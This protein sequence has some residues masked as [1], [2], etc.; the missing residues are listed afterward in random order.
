MLCGKGKL[1][2]HRCAAH[3]INLVCKA[4]F[5]I[6]NS[7]VH[8][9][10]EGVKYIEGS[11]SRKQKFEEIIQQLGI[12]YKK[13]PKIDISTRWNSTYLM[14]ED[15]LELKR[16][17]ESLARQEPEYTYAPSLEEGEKAK[18]VCRFLKTFYDATKV[19][20]GSLYPTANLYFMRFGRLR[21]L[22]RMEFLRLTSSRLSSI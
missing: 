10:R 19:M 8:K 13:R 1:L 20:S 18:M 2:H 17:F 4:G 6:I 15:C 16:A 21:L 12:R 14:L 22:W 3:V 9:V 5:E 11:T 7:I